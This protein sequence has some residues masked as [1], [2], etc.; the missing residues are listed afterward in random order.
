MG[1]VKTKER[2]GL[3]TKHPDKGSR[4]KGEQLAYVVARAIE[5][6]ENKSKSALLREA[7]YSA[8]TIDATPS[9]PWNTRGFKES[10][11]AQGYTVDKIAKVVSEAM[12]ATEVVVFAG[13]ANETAIPAH[14]VRMAAA[15]MAAQYTGVEVQRSQHI[16]VDVQIESS[17]AAKLLGL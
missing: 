4:S 13:Q 2:M 6:G 8:T 17:E 10:M 16:N 1:K 3:K 7:G 5:R 14:S 15:K 12:G 9:R 11:E